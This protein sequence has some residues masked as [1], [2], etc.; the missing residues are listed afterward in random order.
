MNMIRLVH[1]CLLFA[2]IV[3]LL[4]VISPSFNR[5][6]ILVADQGV[7]ASRSLSSVIRLPGS[8][9]ARGHWILLLAVLRGRFLIYVGWRLMH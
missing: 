5:L 4:I 7:T 1:R 9:S 2:A 6:W 8:T 3:A